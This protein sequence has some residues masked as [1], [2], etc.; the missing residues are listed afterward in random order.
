M[1]IVDLTEFYSEKGG[2]RHHL[3]Q[4]GRILRRLGHD[5]VI[6]APGAADG[7]SDLA[8]APGDGRDD[9]DRRAA[10]G[11][12]RVFR[13][14]G[15]TLPYDS[16]YHLLWRL[17]KARKVVMLEKPDVFQINS[18]YLAAILQRGLKAE[19]VGIK[20]LWWHADVIDTYAVERLR[21]FW[22]PARSEAIARPLWALVRAITAGCDAT[23]A[24]SQHQV[25]KLLAHGA[26]RVRLL[27]FGIDK[28]LFSPRARRDA[29]RA[30]AFPS[31]SDAP[32]FVAMGRLSVEKH[33]P[34]VLEGF[35]RFRAGRE[36][37]LIIF[38]DGPE[39]AALERRFA[40]RDDVRF[41]GFERDPH[42]IATALASADAFVHGC[43]FE[44]F[45]LSVAQAVACGLPV[46]VP[47]QGG[48]AELARPSF[49]EFYP[50]GDAG[51]CAA[52]LERLCLRDAAA[53][54][55]G[56]LRARASIVGAVEQVEHTVEVYR[57]LLAR[58]GKAHDNG[59]HSFGNDFAS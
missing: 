6:I 5:H 30:S 41:M 35:A 48:A 14:G 53:L 59:K 43:P 9:D 3:D 22:G 32:I 42:Q 10:G 27:P 17:D 11:T 7:I 19:N 57:E 24:A 31:P 13:I 40:Q 21:P 16:N 54:R 23:F 15:P 8:P 46:V 49:A 58:R 52:A 37:R 47:D 55:D 56:A 18:P 45:G 25:D 38:G 44:T 34:V 51:A 39:R 4:K 50:A 28:E 1:K 36:A 12:A 29:W 26:P 20:T 2:V 33:W